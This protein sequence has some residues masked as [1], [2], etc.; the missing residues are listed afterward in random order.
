MVRHKK[1][2]IVSGYFNPLH[3]GHIEYFNQ[4]KSLGDFLVVIV[5][6]DYQRNL[7]GS[8]EFQKEDERLLIVSSL[9]MVDDVYL[10]VDIDR[11]VRL[12]LQMIDKI[13]GIGNELIFA[14]GGDQNNDTIPERETC[15]R[16]GIQLADGLGDKIQSSSW[17]LK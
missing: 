16:L 9:K 10:S 13:Y 7:K 15:E 14:N 6:N 5:N 12:S 11:T 17:L 1:V 2:V 4:A 8:Q 3:K